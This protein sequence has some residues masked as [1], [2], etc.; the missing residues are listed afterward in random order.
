MNK[1]T[2]FLTLLLLISLVF[3]SGLSFETAA[4]HVAELQAG[5]AT[6][7]ATYAPVTI[8]FELNGR[9]IILNGKVNSQP[10][11]FV[12]DTGDQV[13]IVDLDVAKRMN[14]SLSGEVRVGGAGAAVSTGALVKDASFTLNGL[15]GFS[16]PVK[17]A[18]PLGK[19]L[20][21]RAGRAFEGIIGA[22]FIQEFV[23]EIDYQARV[24][25]LHDKDKFVYNG[26]GESVP[27]KLVRGHPIIETEVTPV[28]GAPLK[29]K[30]VFDIGAGLALALYSPFVAE[31]RLLGPES[32]T[33]RSLGGA[34]AGGETVG[35]IGRVSELKLGNYMIKNPI[36]LFSEDKAGA[37]ASEDLAGNIGARVANKFRVFLDYGRKRIIFEP[38]STFGTPYDYASAG[39]SIIAEGA[40]YR[41]FRVRAVLENSPASEAGLQTD[42]IITAV[43]DQSA[44]ELT[45]SKL[46]EMFERRVPYKLTIRRGEQTLHI[47]LTPRQLV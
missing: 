27:I 20:S 46:N 19:T 26:P 8:P 11:T 6:A 2:P 13:A 45:L 29:G 47:T 21:A 30:F 43:N 38:N 25:K 23:V 28:G 10:I 18:L 16:Q 31:N 41:T 44:A 34:G 17:M 33:I 24:L 37:F 3:A 36:T 22:E 42:D 1:R 14:L 7:K 15:D 35:R 9:H 4:I 12:L 40:D 5:Q 32:K 39:L